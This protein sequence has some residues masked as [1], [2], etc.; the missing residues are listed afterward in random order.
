MWYVDHKM[1]PSLI[2]APQQHE[3]VDG[4]FVFASNVRVRANAD[5]SALRAVIDDLSRL[6]RHPVQRHDDGQVILTI[7][8]T[9]DPLIPPQGYRLHISPEHVELIANDA[10]GL[11]Y[12]AMT[13]AQI[14][15]CSKLLGHVDKLACRRILD[16]P[17]FAQ[18]GF[19]LDMGRATFTIPLLKRM[20]RIASRLKMNFIHLHLHDNEL[21]SVRYPGT[22]LGSE[23]PFALTIDQFA[24]L[25]EY[26]AALHVNIVPELESWGHAGSLL[27]HHPELYGAS[28][29]HG[30]GHAFGIGPETFALL[31]RMFD[32]WIGILPDGAMLHTGLDE[33]NWRLLPGADPAVYNRDT[34]V[35]LIHDLI[36]ERARAAGK[37]ITMAMW[38]PPQLNCAIPP[39]IR[40]EIVL[41]PWWYTVD[42]ARGEHKVGDLMAQ[43][44]AGPYLC[45]AGISVIHEQAAVRCTRQ[46]IW[47]SRDR[48]DCLGVNVTLWG[49]NDMSGRLLSIVDGA[50]LMWKP[51]AT[52]TGETESEVGELK[53]GRMISAMRMWQAMTPD[54][55]P[56]A[57][58]ADRGVEVCFGEYRYGD[59]AGEFV[60]PKWKPAK[61]M[62]EE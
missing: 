7:N 52:R 45:G 2:P 19:M 29:P 62:F 36:A 25:I 60:V 21:N 20:V 5:G 61:M 42:R 9:P 15:G 49:A 56:D 4:E 33:A 58:N 37:R 13:L 27:Q 47:Q 34:L 26:A 28:R 11:H 14:V 43:T 54:A 31:E 35:K 55:E 30:R 16:W 18:R 53:Y 23:N 6:L 24:E 39:E 44:P 41:E 3:L 51:D 59:K 32:A 17:H 22:L 46:W 48:S 1:P 12:A 8:Q 57:I 50:D 10:V 38:G 40:S